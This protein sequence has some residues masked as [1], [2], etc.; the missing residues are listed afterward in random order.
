MIA[1]FLTSCRSQLLAATLVVAPVLAGCGGD[2]VGIN[3]DLIGTWS[4]AGVL[5][6]GMQILEERTFAVD[7]TFT[8]VETLQPDLGDPGSDGC[9]GRFNLHG[10]WSTSYEDP[11]FTLTQSNVTG[12]SAK[13]DCKDPSDDIAESAIKATA[14]IV[15]GETGDFTYQIKDGKLTLD[16]GGATRE[17]TKK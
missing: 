8:Y 1:N 5:A 6:G 17:Y 12:T 13:T 14:P 9:V 11:E 7:A 16:F 3:A 10:Y 4:Y 2:S 15:A